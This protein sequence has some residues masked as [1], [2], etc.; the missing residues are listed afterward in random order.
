[1]NTIYFSKVSL[2]SHEVYYFSDDERIKMVDS[3]MLALKHNFQFSVDNVKI[4]EDGDRIFEQVDYTLSIIQKQNTTIEGI[5]YRKSNLFIKKKLNGIDELKK[6]PVQNTED[7]H[8]YYDVIHECVAFIERSRFRRKMF[9]QAFAEM[10]N[11][12]EKEAGYSYRFYLELYNYGMDIDEMKSFIR[13]KNDLIKIEIL[14]KPINPDDDIRRKLENYRQVLKETNA[15]ERSVTYKGS[16]AVPIDGGA[17]IISSDIDYLN[18]ISQK[19]HIDMRELTKRGYFQIKTTDQ[20][21]NVSS[22]TEK[23]PFVKRI[24]DASDLAIVAAQEI[25]KIIMKGI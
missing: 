23:K 18:E 25:T 14:Y 19:A 8:F 4:N 10:L 7:I 15:T 16:K 9:N 5:L 11:R 21:G 22:T 13:E 6:I 24:K 20:N 17:P 3:I 2:F 1:M 12:A